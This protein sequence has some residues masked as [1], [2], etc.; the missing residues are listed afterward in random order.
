MRRGTPKKGM[1][2]KGLPLESP[3][4]GPLPVYSMSSRAQHDYS[5]TSRS[6]D[7]KKEPQLGANVFI[8][9]DYA[10]GMST[11]F[12]TQ[13]PAVLALRVRLTCL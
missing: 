10:H 5:R 6:K 7:K 11:R 2:E 13:F 9:R 3:R 12:E 1:A 4:V 8:E